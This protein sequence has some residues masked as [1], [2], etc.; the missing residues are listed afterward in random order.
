MEKQIER[1]LFEL[2][3]QDPT[4]QEKAFLVNKKR[5][6]IGR[7]ESCDI[8]IRSKLVSAVHAVI[9]IRGNSAIIFDMNSKN[10]TFVNA[11]KVITKE[12]NIND[13][14]NIASHPLIFK[15]Y[16][17]SDLPKPLD[18]LETRHGSASILP[19]M[20]EEALTDNKS[21]PEADKS[22]EEIPY[23]V[24]PLAAD[25][26]AEFSEYIF[27]DI[28]TL[29]PIFKYD[30]SKHSVEIMILFEDRVYSVD[31]LPIENR[32]YYL[33]GN[34]KV[35]RDIEFPYLQKI[36]RIPVVQVKN[37]S[38]TVNGITGYELTHLANERAQIVKNSDSILLL[39]EDI[40]KM[41]KGDL[42]I[43]VRVINSP[44][45][46]AAAPLFRRDKEFIKALI[47]VFLFIA[48]F[49][50]LASIVEVNKELE[51]D[52]TPERIATILY[53]TKYK[54]TKKDAVEK[55][56]VKE[57]KAQTSPNK[58]Q[59]E[60]DTKKQEIAK[61]TS[62]TKKT[63]KLQG[64]ETAKKVEPVKKGQKTENKKSATKQADNP[65][66]KAVSKS[67]SKS[68]NKPR[69]ARVKTASP[70]HVDTYKAVNFKSTMSNLLA[71]GGDLQG[72][73]TAVDSS[74]DSTSVNIGGNVDPNLQKANTST[75]LGNLTGASVGKLSQSRGAEGLGDKKTIYTAGI[76]AE[77]IVLG[78]YDPDVIRRILREHIPQF[79]YC[80]Q[81]ELDKAGR[82]Y[83]GLVRF[84]FTIGASGNVARA[85]ATSS[86]LM[87]NKIRGCVVNVLRG[88]E[89]PAPL[90]GGVVEVEQPMNF[91]ARNL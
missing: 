82:E 56:K 27:E 75:N 62:V 24:Y 66:N 76:P 65:K 55:T 85:N 10:G 83:E 28:D 37:G 20:L 21:R 64:K 41:S 32:D 46:V 17:S 45:K 72:A 3:S 67:K 49:L 88:I 29:Y 12:V 84:N 57:K 68:Q 70:G 39:E 35:K 1:K 31:Y 89:F 4:I 40:I 90:G 36:E 87:S 16:L 59:K 42:E 53:K 33:A 52:D 54:V 50:T 18:I 81:Q 26:R 60:T 47:F 23:V 43:Y 6:L 71:K 79:R 30:M 8:V 61:Q 48:I 63:D 25:P 58:V 69:R 13:E 51:K 91:G 77:T 14:I 80:Y 2:V 11:E 19:E 15:E 7:A 5:M 38:V 86:T 44:P 34:K 73:S 74:S 78:N 22:A 9:E